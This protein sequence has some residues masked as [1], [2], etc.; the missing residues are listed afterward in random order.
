VVL[1]V[2]VVLGLLLLLLLWSMP[3]DRMHP[4]VDRMD[5]ILILGWRVSTGSTVSTA[6]L[7]PMVVVVAV[8][9][10]I[11]LA[12]SLAVVVAARKGIHLIT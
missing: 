8:A 5:R 3:M 11:M 4:H 7:P 6:W 12:L 9:A 2:A 10:V 1:V